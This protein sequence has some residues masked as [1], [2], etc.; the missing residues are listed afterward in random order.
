M[1]SVF[2]FSHSFSLFK[3]TISGHMFS[4]AAQICRLIESRLETD[5]K[6]TGGKL[7]GRNASSPENANI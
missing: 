6:H 5:F 4:L 3:L 7:H 1:P 2:L